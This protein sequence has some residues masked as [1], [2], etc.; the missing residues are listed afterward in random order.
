MKIWSISF[1]LL[2]GSVELY[3]WFKMMQI[4]LPVYIGLGILLAIASNADKSFRPWTFPSVLKS[5]S[6]EPRAIPDPAPSVVPKPP[7]TR[8]SISFKINP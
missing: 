2:F 4:P 1:I 6:S 8:N 7:Q 5:E 3:Q